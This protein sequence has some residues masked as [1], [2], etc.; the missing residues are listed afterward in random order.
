MENVYSSEKFMSMSSLDKLGGD[1]SA[2]GFLWVL[3]DVLGGKSEG[4][5]DLK[6]L[7][8]S[9]GVSMAEVYG[10]IGVLEDSF[11]IATHAEREGRRVRI[12]T[13]ASRSQEAV[14]TKP[15]TVNF[16][17]DYLTQRGIIPK[18]VPKH[19]DNPLKL[20]TAI[21]LGD[22][23][24][25][26][27]GFYSVLKSTLNDRREFTYSMNDDNIPPADGTRITSLA[28]AL[29]NMGM[30]SAYE[31]KKSPRR[32]ITAKIADTPDAHRFISGEWLELWT[33][34]RTVSDL[35]GPYECVRNL[36]VMLPG[37]E[38][39]EF[40][41]LIC[42]GGNLFWVEAKTAKYSS[43]ITKYSRIAG[44][45]GRSPANAFLVAPDAAKDSSQS[46]TCCNLED[47]PGLFRES[48]MTSR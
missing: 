47:F 24:A 11:V 25:T 34:S 7:A 43:Y 18:A 46:I 9:L 23:F 22:N 37:D 32:T 36:S 17:T 38:P 8:S 21:N 40:D 26:L 2:L 19:E 3:H 42:S 5:V 33:Y 31:Y 39:F 15:D 41:L 28:N 29:H 45:L 35:A 10:Y 6:S 14:S 30:L 1:F 12:L 20:K 4:V 44:L 48:L 27:R 16:I 13:E